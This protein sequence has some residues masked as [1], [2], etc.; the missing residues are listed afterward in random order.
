MNNIFKTTLW[1]LLATLVA[2]C[3]SFRD[4]SDPYDGSEPIKDLSGVWKISGV[5]R[6][7]IDI[8]NQMDF[9]QFRLN[10][11]ADGTYSIDNYLPFVV[12]ENGTWKTDDPQYVYSLSFQENSATEPMKVDIN[13]PISNGVRNMQISLS[14]GCSSNA[15]V[16]SMERVTNQTNSQDNGTQ[17]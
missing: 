3:S 1:V 4:D 6:N 9:S 5:T 8:S 13:Y 7:A 11:N 2:S 14:P 15:Y 16:Y 17:E 10:L 12:K